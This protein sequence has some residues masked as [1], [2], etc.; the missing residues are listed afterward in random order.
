MKVFAATGEA[1]SVLTDDINIKEKL[2]V[3][4]YNGTVNKEFLKY[5]SL[6]GRMDSLQAAILSYRLNILESKLECRIKM[7]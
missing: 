6:N 2:D 5:P 4:R 7:Q 3:L 1:G